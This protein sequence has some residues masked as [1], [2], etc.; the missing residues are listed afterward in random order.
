[1]DILATISKLIFSIQGLFFLIVSLGLIGF[2]IYFIMNPPKADPDTNKDSTGIGM[3]AM[4]VVL[5]GITIFIGKN[6]YK[7]NQVAKDFLLLEL[8][9]KLFKA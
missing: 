6:I 9:R 1:M 2:G 7:N 4:G 8:S 3:L 5:L